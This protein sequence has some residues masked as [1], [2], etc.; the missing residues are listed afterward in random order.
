VTRLTLTVAE[1]HRRFPLPWTV[2]QIPD[3]YKVVD[4]SGRSLAYVYGRDTLAD[5]YTAHVLT[6]DEARRIASHIAMLP[7]FFFGG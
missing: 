6:L 3:G 7:E 1:A 4:A 5:A 2:E